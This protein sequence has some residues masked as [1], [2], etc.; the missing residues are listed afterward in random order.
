MV[1]AAAKDDTTTTDDDK[2]GDKGGDDKGAQ[3]GDDDDKGGNGDGGSVT[4]DQL[5][6]KIDVEEIM[7]E[8]GLDSPGDLKEF[9]GGLSDMKGKIGEHDLDTLIENTKILQKYQADWQLQEE[10][11]KREKETP[12]ETIK[13]LE[14]ENKEILNK[15]KNQN[16]RQKA[17]KAAEVALS[18]FG[19]TIDTVIKSAKDLPK[20]YQP[21]VS[22]FMGVD[23]PINE[24]DITDKAAIR[25]LTKAGI[26]KITAFEQAVIKRYRAGK[27][28]IPKV[29]D[30]DAAAGDTGADDRNP[31]TLKEA[32]SLLMQGLAGFGKK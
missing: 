5:S 15:S 31:K 14:K 17:S 2:A 26:A 12:E 20:E 1:E 23:N 11:R 7:E 10:E 3:G 9:I 29:K 30:A 32:K 6:T 19:D 18:E 16:N 27:T 22:E 24:I 8:Y 4:D 21:F 13:R 25:R 28:K